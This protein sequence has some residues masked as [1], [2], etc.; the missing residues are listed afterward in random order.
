MTVPEHNT[1]DLMSQLVEARGMVFNLM[2]QSGDSGRTLQFLKSCF[3]ADTFEVVAH[4][5]LDHLASIDLKSCVLIRG[6][7]GQLFYTLSP[8]DE[9]IDESFMSRN[10]DKGRLIEDKHRLI[11]NYDN[12]S[13]LITNFPADD[14]QRGEL[15]DSLAVLMDGIEAKVININ[16]E[17]QAAEARSVKDAFFALM[18]HELR[19]PLNAI[20]GFSNHLSRRLGPDLSPRNIKAFDAIKQNS[21]HLLVLVDDILTLSELKNN[22][23]IVHLKTVCLYDLL[24]KALSALSSM[25]KEYNVSVMLCDRVEWMC[26]ID[27]ERMLDVFI[28]VLSNSIKYSPGGRVDI[29]FVAPSECSHNTLAVSF[30]D[31]GKG[32]PPEKTEEVFHHFSERDDPA[33]QKTRSCG[34]SLYVAREI[35]RLNGGTIEMTSI[36]GQGSEFRVLLPSVNLAEELAGTRLN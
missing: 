15:R 3:Q 5:L 25:S 19:T 22:D 9:M 12:C 30:S 23:V 17:Y 6:A 8:D 11:V 33:T 20:V 27:P 16:L 4:H 31:N 10:L 2:R 14:Q 24:A 29:S 7:E 26:H 35:T 36:L 21:E 32:I 34:I 13:L 18:S 1:E 28:G